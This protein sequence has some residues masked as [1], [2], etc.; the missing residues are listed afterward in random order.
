ML[1]IPRLDCERR[2]DVLVVPSVAF[3]LHELRSL[4]FAKLQL[5][6]STAFHLKLWVQSL[7]LDSGFG[8]FKL[9]IYSDLFLVAFFSPSSC[10]TA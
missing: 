2:M 10:F 7:E 4:R 3:Q 8:R 5:G 1:R 9:P 6:A